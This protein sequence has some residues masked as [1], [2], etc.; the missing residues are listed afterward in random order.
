MKKLIPK[1][2][3][4]NKLP[5]YQSNYNTGPL[6][7]WSSIVNGNLPSN[8]IGSEEH[9]YPLQN[10]DVV[11]QIP[12]YFSSELIPIDGTYTQNFSPA[13]IIEY[14]SHKQPFSDEVSAPDMV[15]SGRQLIYRHP[16]QRPDTSY[17]V[18]MPPYTNGEFDENWIKQQNQK[19]AKQKFIDDLSHTNRTY[20]TSIKHADTN[21]D[22][23]DAKKD[24][25]KQKR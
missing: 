3:L 10:V 4:G 12:L 13:K 8:F 17:W 24:Y 21:Q 15:I 18:G 7:Y 16:W 22:L 23:K 1:H 11:G 25:K 2:Q 6:A 14:I 5:Y 19:T 20:Y 9:P